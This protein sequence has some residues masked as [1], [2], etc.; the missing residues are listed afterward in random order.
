MD[1]LCAFW[2][3]QGLWTLRYPAVALEVPA[4]VGQVQAA[5]EGFARAA[6]GT[7][8]MAQVLQQQQQQ[9]QLQQRQQ[10]RQQQQQ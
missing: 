4:G 3:I 2:W 8:S 10:Q 5:L 7:T 9:Q 6:P 1:A